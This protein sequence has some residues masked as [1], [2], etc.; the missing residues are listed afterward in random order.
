MKPDLDLS[1]TTVAGSHMR[2]EIEEQAA[3]WVDFVDRSSTTLTSIASELISTPSRHVYLVG[4]GSSHHAAQYGQLI[5]RDVPGLSP[6]LIEP[7]TVFPPELDQKAQ[8][9]ILIAVSQSGQSPD[10]I[11]TAL[12]ARDRGMFLVAICNASASP[13]ADACDALVD[14][15]AGPELAVPATKTFT[16]ECIALFVLGSLALKIPWLR[17]QSQ[18]R[19][20][21][22]LSAL[23]GGSV[24]NER[25]RDQASSLDVASI[26]VC[27]SGYAAPMAREA[28]LKFLE[29]GRL[30]AT[31]WGLADALHGP[32]A[33]LSATSLVVPM[34]G[35]AESNGSWNVLRERVKSAE[36]PVLNLGMEFRDLGIGLWLETETRPIA[37]WQLLPL[38]QIEL[39]QRLA[40]ELAVMRGLNPDAPA[41]LFKV[42]ETF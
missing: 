20:L 27:G 26:F 6:L 25:I 9:P 40:V 34:Q 35:T 38:L 17:V 36:A 30:P 5:L 11:Q 28:A 1:L 39:L 3:R 10:L 12:S 31:G 2:E 33:N 14:L 19:N 24:T 41:G 42:T 37:Q 16:L 22:N 29:T 7:G 21:A 32:T 15:A 4:R 23:I 8:R 18:I 13:L